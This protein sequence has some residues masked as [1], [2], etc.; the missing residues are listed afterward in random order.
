MASQTSQNVPP[1][2]PNAT[3][4]TNAQQPV[5]QDPPQVKQDAIKQAE[6]IFS[7]NVETLHVTSAKSL[8]S[9][10]VVLQLELYFVYFYMVYLLLITFLK[11]KSFMQH[12]DTWQAIVQT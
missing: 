5:V 11:G 2:N 9:L 3:N 1:P 6:D 8:L 10:Q 7:T 12:T 4:E